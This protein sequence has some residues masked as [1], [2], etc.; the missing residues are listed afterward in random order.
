MESGTAY[1]LGT[2]NAAGEHACQSTATH[3]ACSVRSG[4]IMIWRHVPSR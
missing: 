1:P 2:F 3:V 4:E